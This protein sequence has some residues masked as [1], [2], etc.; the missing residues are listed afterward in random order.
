MSCREWGM[1]MAPSFSTSFYPFFPC[2]S[3][4]LSGHCATTSCHH[5]E[6]SLSEV[7]ENSNCFTRHKT[8]LKKLKK[9]LS[10]PSSELLVDSRS[11]IFIFYPFLLPSEQRGGEFRAQFRAPS[12]GTNGP[13]FKPALLCFLSNSSNYRAQHQLCKKIHQ[14][15]EGE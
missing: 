9:K 1:L 14:N 15:W 6:I 10:Q 12:R 13:N 8:C 11:D 3:G 5:R 4:L 2:K 7:K